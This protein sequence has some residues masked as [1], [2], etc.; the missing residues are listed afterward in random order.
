M[1]AGISKRTLFGNMQVPRQF[2]PTG[3]DRCAAGAYH[4]EWSGQ[5]SGR[6]I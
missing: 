4:C 5:A 6:N 2:G 1:I 3:E